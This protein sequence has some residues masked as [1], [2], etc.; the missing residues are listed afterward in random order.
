MKWEAPRRWLFVAC[1]ATVPFRP[2]KLARSLVRG[3]DAV[4]LLRVFLRQ[5]IDPEQFLSAAKTNSQS[6]RV[7]MVFLADAISPEL[8]RVV[9]SLNVQRGQCCW[10]ER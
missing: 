3:L 7:R 1:E 8:R 2:T 4:G 9:E 10:C 6:G 5:T